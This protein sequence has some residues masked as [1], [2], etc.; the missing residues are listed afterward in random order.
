M[1]SFKIF[2]SIFPFY[3]PELSLSIF[4]TVANLQEDK[5][6]KDLIMHFSLHYLKPFCLAEKG[7]LHSEE[8]STDAS[9]N[10]IFAF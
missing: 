8:H 10:L 3:F 9:W 2:N 1:K 7:V 6:K 4:F 5:Y